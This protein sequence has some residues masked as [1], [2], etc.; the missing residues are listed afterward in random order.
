MIN[1]DGMRN[2]IGIIQSLSPDRDDLPQADYG[3][4][5]GI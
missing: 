5:L 3:L 4:Q 1:A 2:T